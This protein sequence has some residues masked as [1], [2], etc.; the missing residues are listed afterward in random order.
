MSWCDRVE[1][2]KQIHPAAA[3]VENHKKDNNTELHF[4]AEES[5]LSEEQKQNRI[6]ECR[7][8]QQSLYFMGLSCLAKRANVI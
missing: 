7:N 6:K 8:E 3:K 2:V 5:V 4:T 1:T